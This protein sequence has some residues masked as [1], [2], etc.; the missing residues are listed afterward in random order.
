MAEKYQKSF[1]Q[2]AN[3]ID[4]KALLADTPSLPVHYPRTTPQPQ[5]EGKNFEWFIGNN[6]AGRNGG[7]RLTLKPAREAQ[8]GLPLLDKRGQEQ[9]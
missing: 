4:L 2:L 5:S 3:V 7:P 9:D 8:S 1:D 6:K